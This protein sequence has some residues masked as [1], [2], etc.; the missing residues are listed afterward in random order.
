MNR[1]RGILEIEQ[2]DSAM[3]DGA[4]FMWVIYIRG[5]NSPWVEDGTSYSTKKAATEEGKKWAT[6]LDIVIEEET[7]RERKP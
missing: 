3:G 6:K 7:F 1:V 5:E 2:T 4:V